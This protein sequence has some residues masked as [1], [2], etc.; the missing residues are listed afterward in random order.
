MLY[1]NRRVQQLD[2][3]AATTPP[4]L[5]IIFPAN[6]RAATMSTWCFMRANE[7]GHKTGA[8]AHGKKGIKTNL[9]QIRQPADG[10]HLPAM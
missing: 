9:Q 8:H 2:L 10:N 7:R 5:I 4:S 6:N 3:R 1:V